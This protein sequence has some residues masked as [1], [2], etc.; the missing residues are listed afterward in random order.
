M[1]VCLT[2]PLQLCVQYLF[3]LDQVA[4]FMCASM[5]VKVQIFLYTIHVSRYGMC[6]IRCIRCELIVI[7]ELLTIDYVLIVIT[8]TLL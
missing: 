8:V 3:R 4:N 5:C 2:D 7:Y 6:T 1:R